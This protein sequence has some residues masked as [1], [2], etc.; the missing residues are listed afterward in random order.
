M[1]WQ[2]FRGQF[3]TLIVSAVLVI[4]TLSIYEDIYSLLKTTN[5]DSLWILFILKYSV[6]ILIGLWN[7]HYFKTI[8]IKPLKQ[9][10]EENPLEQLEPIEKKML[11]KTSLKSKTDFILEKYASKK[12]A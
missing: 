10:I 8:K 12:D 9:K 5:K 1:L 11:Q 3:V 2:K 7:I 4:L 6:L